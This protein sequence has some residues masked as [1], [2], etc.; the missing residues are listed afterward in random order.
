M[1][2]DTSGLNWCSGVFLLLQIFSD[3]VWLPEIS[4]A[5][6]LYMIFLIA[7]SYLF[8]LEPN[9]KMGVRLG[10]YKMVQVGNDQE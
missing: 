7:C 1:L 9:Q 10:A 2:P 6:H 4:I 5:E 3:F 8:I